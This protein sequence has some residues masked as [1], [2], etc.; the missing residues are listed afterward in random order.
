M[1]APRTQAQI[2]AAR[3]NGA[4]SRGPASVAGKARACRNATRYGLASAEGAF[5]LLAGEDP[6]AWRA[7]LGA[8]L[9]RHA[10][11]DAAERRSV[12]RMACA[13]WL[14]RRLLD[15]EGR[16]MDAVAAEGAPPPPGL[17]TV[18]ALA[19]YRVRVEGDLRRAD[20]ELAG[21]R[22]ARPRASGPP[23]A[24]GDAR[25]CRLLG[26]A[27]DGGDGTNACA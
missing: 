24:S 9:A 21:F 12:E 15:L 8:L 25:L 18:R 11:A 27:G 4:L 14:R 3:R 19:A 17:A 5:R 22:R 6:A 16:V 2:E 10:P 26:R 7:N 20:D 23:A 13:A 1:A